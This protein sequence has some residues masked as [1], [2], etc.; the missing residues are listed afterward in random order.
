[1]SVRSRIVLLIAAVLTSASIGRAE[2]RMLERRVYPVADLVVSMGSAAKGD[3]SAPSA[4]STTA[5][6]VSRERQPATG[7][8]QLIKLIT[9]KIA[10]RSWSE[11]GGPGNIEYFPLTESLV[12]NQSPAIQ[13]QI[14]DM[15]AALRRFYDLQIAVEVKFAT[16][17]DEVFKSLKR[18]RILGDPKN[19]KHG[20]SEPRGVAFLSDKEM[21]LLMEVLQSNTRTSVMQAPK[22]TLFNGQT[23]R[24]NL[25]DKQIFVT[26]LDISQRDGR[27]E[28]RPKTEEVPLGVRMHLR[29]LVSADRRF[30]RLHFD[31]TLSNLASGE[32][33]RVP[34]TVPGQSD[35]DRPSESKPEMVTQYI[36]QP[37]VEK[38][39][40]DQT[41]VIPDTNTAVL[42]G[43]QQ[44]QVTASTTQVPILGDLPY[45]GEL[46][47]T[48][49]YHHETQHL[50]ILVTPRILVAPEEERKQIRERDNEDR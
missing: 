13:G 20:K 11:R 46:F 2:D 48:R 3:N 15:L 5:W 34:I 8:N 12:V 1:M 22:L 32:V 30:V 40:V 36:E 4:T 23:A 47:R 45:I 31:T 44:S 25:L 14:A 6:A 33:P 41:L 18:G 39:H 38:A 16:V 42:S 35:K 26:G 17:S 24:F 28:C 37:R 9:S 49:E 43:W 7:E 50:L 21:F 10:P 19:G 27:I 29:P